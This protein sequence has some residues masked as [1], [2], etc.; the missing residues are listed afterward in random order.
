MT[1]KKGVSILLWCA[2]VLALLSLL[3][4]LYYSF[5]Y[6][7]DMLLGRAGDL[8]RT[9]SNAAELPQNAYLSDDGV[10]F[11]E[12]GNFKGAYRMYGGTYEPMRLLGEEMLAETNPNGLGKENCVQLS[13]GS[14]ATVPNWILRTVNM[15][16]DSHSHIELQEEW[17]EEMPYQAEIK[18]QNGP[19]FL[20]AF[21]SCSNPKD[22]G[23][24][25]ALYE[26]MMKY[27]NRS[28]RAY[29]GYQNWEGQTTGWYP[30]P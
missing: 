21:V 28:A 8:D 18:Y 13:D 11:F 2:G 30:A 4:L 9:F 22:T 6:K 26:D 10:Q 29:D 19:F 23:G 20:Y 1:Q 12:K 5:F 15:S 7:P 24:C 14:L 16:G 27:L 3:G 25:R 17:E